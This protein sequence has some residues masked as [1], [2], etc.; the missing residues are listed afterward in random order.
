MP[1][2]LEAPASPPQLPV[3]LKP[4]QSFSIARTAFL[5]VSFLLTLFLSARLLAERVLPALTVKAMTPAELESYALRVFDNG[6]GGNS[7]SDNSNSVP[8]TVTH[9]LNQIP[10]YNA[11][12]SVYQD[13]TEEEFSAFM[14]RHRDTMRPYQELAFKAAQIHR[15]YNNSKVFEVVFAV[16]SQMDPGSDIGK[17]AAFHRQLEHS[18]H[19]PSVT[20]EDREMLFEQLA[21]WVESDDSKLY[22][23]MAGVICNNHNRPKDSLRYYEPLAQEW[24]VGPLLL[25]R[26]Y[27]DL[28][29]R[30]GRDYDSMIYRKSTIE[31]YPTGE[32]F[33]DLA[34][35]YRN[36]DRRNEALRESKKAIEISPK[37]ASQW[38]T[39]ALVLHR[40]EQFDDAVEA[41][42]TAISLDPKQ[43]MAWV[44]Q[45]SALESLEKPEEAV[46][47]LRNGLKTLASNQTM[48]DMLEAL[49]AFDPQHT[50]YLKLNRKSSKP[51]PLLTNLNSFETKLLELYAAGNESAAYDQIRLEWKKLK[52]FPRLLKMVED[53]DT[54]AVQ[55][56]VLQN[57]TQLTSELETAFL[58]AVDLRSGFAIQGSNLIFVTIGHLV[59]ESK[60]GKLALL[61][62][63]LDS[64]A[65]TSKFS[66]EEINQ[67]LHLL[68]N[69]L[70]PRSVSPLELW[71]GGMVCRSL[72]RPELGVKFYERL[73]ESW[74][75]GP[76]LMHQ[77]YANHLDEL[78]R[79]S[80][81]LRHR[82][83]ATSL[84]HGP[85]AMQA[86][87]HTLENLY[88]FT[89]AQAYHQKAVKANPNDDTKWSSLGFSLM[90]NG[91]HRKAIRCF[92]IAIK[93]NNQ[94]KNA[95]QNWAA[96]LCALDQPAEAN[97]LLRLANRIAPG[98][99]RIKEE[100]GYLAN[101]DH[102]IEEE[103]T[104]EDALK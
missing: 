48:Q 74:S 27:G 56:F 3:A 43:A 102:S 103:L 31:H 11:A 66:E 99:R 78:E 80:E 14:D 84:P 18:R 96:C 85:W 82:Y 20:Q 47:V 40:S 95:W 69:R 53:N 93:R 54:L 1:S 94:S 92:K 76:A 30:L 97:Q 72:N 21:S 77:T 13:G 49:Q 83:I 62:S 73:S 89:E 33:S 50:N 91:Q 6:D 41:A 57:R 37:G 29:Q 55:S 9:Q 36:L 22:R 68:A 58:Y 44:Y 7:E 101:Y 63:D 59:P 79:Y 86:F 71:L 12:L 15:R 67:R 42:K 38:T 100:L 28:L 16:I 46:K 26:D 81:A 104:L 70:Q 35:S 5:G 45:A 51:A 64:S 32:N 52:S 39:R 61:I 65:L 2:P 8:T 24:R 87:G 75:P 90:K 4:K 98:N 34:I 60:L 25:R 19:T 10:N 23:Y 17:R 88:R